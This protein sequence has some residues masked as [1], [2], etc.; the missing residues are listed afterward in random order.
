MTLR[1]PPQGAKCADCQ[2]CLATVFAGD[3]P[4]CWECDL[5]QTCKGKQPVPAPAVM[6][7]PKK[8]ATPVVPWGRKGPKVKPTPA[9]RTDIPAGNAAAFDRYEPEPAAAP[10]PADP[11]TPLADHYAAVIA[12][13]E[14]KAISLQNDLELITGA[15]L[16][17]LRA[18]RD[19]SVVARTPSTTTQSAPTG[20]LN[21]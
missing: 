10:G 18:L 9:P 3:V 4:V 20:A 15:V 12:D 13:L 19:R 16:P 6:A 11:I 14:D 5:G 1:F 8:A 2:C 21:V 17:S 7:R